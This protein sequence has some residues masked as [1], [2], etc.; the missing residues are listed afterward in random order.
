MSYAKPTSVDLRCNV[1]RKLA[2]T[3]L[4]CAEC[5]I[6]VGPGHADTALVDGLH[7]FTC[8]RLLKRW[9]VAEARIREG[10]EQRQQAM[11]WQNRIG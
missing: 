6:L 2:A 7:C 8:R 10:R 4:R 9:E 1:C 5:G 3:H 11:R